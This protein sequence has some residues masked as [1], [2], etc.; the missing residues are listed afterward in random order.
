MRRRLIVAWNWKGKRHDSKPRIPFLYLRDA[1]RHID[2]G[3]AAQLASLPVRGCLRNAGCH[4]V[5]AE[6]MKPCVHC[7]KPFEPR[8]SST[9]VAC[10]LKCAAAYA[11][12][13]RLA[14]EKAERQQTKARK[15]AIK[16]VS[17][18]ED[19]CRKI[20]LK[21]ARLRDRND[22][23]ISC[24]MSPNYG[25]QWHGSHYRSVGASSNTQFLL[26]NIHKACAQCNLHKGGNREFY[27]P[28]LIEK[29]G[30]ERVEWLDAQN[31]VTKRSGVAY[32]EYLKRFKAVMGKRLR[33]MEKSYG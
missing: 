27:R 21:I 33:R 5:L 11:K 28:R 10:S 18:W 8:Y 13:E 19:E 23:C 31:Q 17:A 14:K 22:G 15:E 9:Q 24:H 29:I 1:L 16:P 26:W 32:V 4:A 7:R 12:R 2:L 20:V 6:R 3:R 30:L 25:G